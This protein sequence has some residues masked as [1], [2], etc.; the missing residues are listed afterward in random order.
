[1]LYFHIVATEIYRAWL[2]TSKQKTLLNEEHAKNKTNIINL[3]YKTIWQPARLR[4]KNNALGIWVKDAT[5]AGL[6]MS[7]KKDVHSKIYNN[8]NHPALEQNMP[9]VITSEI[10]PYLDPNKI[11]TLI[12]HLLNT[13]NSDEQ[14]EDHVKKEIENN[15]SARQ[16]PY[17]LMRVI[18]KSLERTYLVFDTTMEQYGRV[19]NDGN[20]TTPC[21]DWTSGGMQGYRLSSNLPTTLGT[22]IPRLKE[23]EKLRNLLESGAR[24]IFVAGDGGLGKTEFVTATAYVLKDKYNFYFTTFDQTIE[25]TIRNLHFEGWKPYIDSN[26]QKIIKSEQVQYREKLKLLSECKSGILIIDNFNDDSDTIL[27]EL[28]SLPNMDIRFVITTRTMVLGK[29]TQTVSIEPF[30]TVELLELMRKYVGKQYSDEDL[31]NLINAVYCHTLLVDLIARLLVTDVAG[32]HP[33]KLLLELKQKNWIGQ[34]LGEKVP[35]EYNRDYKSKSVLDHL[36]TLFNVSNLSSEAHYILSCSVLIS[37]TGLNADIFAKA[38]STTTNSRV[39]IRKLRDTGWLKYDTNRKRYS[40]HPLIKTICEHNDKTIPTWPKIK[41]FWEEMGQAMDGYDIEVVEQLL[42]FHLGVLGYLRPH[43]LQGVN[44]GGLA[45]AKTYLRIGK[46]LETK[47]DYTSALNFKK[48]SLTILDQLYDAQD[49]EIAKCKAE[50]AQTFTLLGDCMS[51]FNLLDEVSQSY[52]ALSIPHD[53]L[54][55]ADLFYS[56]GLLSNSQHLESAL[57]FA[58]KSVKIREKRLPSNHED[59]ATAYNLIGCIYADLGQEDTAREF[60]IKVLQIRT[61]IYEEDNPKLAAVYNNIGCTYTHNKDLA[62]SMDYLARALRIYEKALPSDHLDLAASYFNVGYTYKELKKYTDALTFMSKAYDVRKNIS[63]SS[64]A[65]S[66][67]LICDAISETYSLMG[68]THQADEYHQKAVRYR[69][70]QIKLQDILETEVRDET[71]MDW[72]SS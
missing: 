29:E 65:P 39:I 67:D 60:F 32:V 57:S 36:H 66:L 43:F 42:Q 54:A 40:I 63:E 37:V 25:Q 4:N 46:L 38:F 6:V 5:E 21:R 9:D 51:A 62:L 52:I 13:V 30:D 10:I 7:G 12:A 53:D 8:C 3:I 34:S 16:L 70:A 15:A 72:T 64:L 61:K 1:M 11:N 24:H 58:Q 14:I 33:R 18:R 48:L 49:L 44:D 17:F 56:L 68:N 35:I 50:I 59:L 55:W 45:Y 20:D 69:K 31:S 27:N 41:P 71:T 26:D 47:G 28:G 19:R 2:P 23:L 22:Y